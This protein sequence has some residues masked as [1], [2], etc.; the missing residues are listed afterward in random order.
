M[1]GDLNLSAM[2]DTSI[3]NKGQEEGKELVSKGYEP[4][5]ENKIKYE[6]MDCKL[7]YDGFKEA[8]QLRATPAS[9]IN[10]AA[11]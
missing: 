3:S 6:K 9:D 7:V 5:V 11:L 2:S 10:S 4:K 8:I 1:F